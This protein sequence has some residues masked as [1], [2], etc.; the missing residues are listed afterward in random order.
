MIIIMNGFTIIDKFSFYQ[1]KL[2][3]LCNVISLKFYFPIQQL[4]ITKLKMLGLKL[5]IQEFTF[6]GQYIIKI[7]STTKKSTFTRLLTSRIR[8]SLSCMLAH[9]NLRGVRKTLIQTSNFS[10]S[11]TC[12]LLRQVVMGR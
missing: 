4:R 8:W 2:M 9:V 11:A 10:S 3:D 7:I 5:L 6:S 12:K 1:A